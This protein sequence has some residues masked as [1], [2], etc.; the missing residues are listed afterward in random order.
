M[1]DFEGNKAYVYYSTFS[2]GPEEDGYK[3]QVGFFRNGRLGD[4]AGDSFTVY[5]G[6]KFCTSD[7]DQDV[8]GQNCA[9]LYQGAWWYNNCH[10]A[11]P[12]GV[13]S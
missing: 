9:E 7:K 5:D 13:Y 1:E 11:N 8:S 6:M 12:N 3:L 10:A 2:V 4:V